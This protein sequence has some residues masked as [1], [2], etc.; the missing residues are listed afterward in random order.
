MNPDGKV[1]T[2]VKGY[3]GG[4]TILDSKDTM[5]WIDAITEKRAPAEAN[6]LEMTLKNWLYTLISFGN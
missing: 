3:K 2:C 4:H 1:L 6:M 5:D